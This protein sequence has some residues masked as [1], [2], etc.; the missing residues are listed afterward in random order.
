MSSRTP[1]LCALV[2]GLALAAPAA[3][4]GDYVTITKQ[5]EVDRP[6]DL[7][8]TRI[9][10]YCAIAEWMKTDCQ[11]VSGT[12]GVGTVRRILK[13]TVVEAMVAQTA[14]SY[15]YWQTQGN[16]AVAAYHG[17]LAAEPIGA[18]RTRLTYTLF[19]DRSALASDAERQAQH[20]RLDGR[21]GGFLSVMKTIAER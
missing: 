7:V 3:Q 20:D 6:A 4:A 10:G 12:G 19:Y 5:V 9:G 11:Y 15:T 13:G 16:M 2:A 17:T 1:I 8:W 18:G 21:F 14:R